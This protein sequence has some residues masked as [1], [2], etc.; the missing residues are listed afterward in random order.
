MTTRFRLLAL[1][2]VTLTLA[3]SAPAGAQQITGTPGWP[4]ATTTIDGKQ[5]PPPDPG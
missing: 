2:A 4:A 5:L 3:M 1:S